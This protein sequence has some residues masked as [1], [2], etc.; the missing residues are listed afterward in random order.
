MRQLN[1]SSVFLSLIDMTST[2]TRLYRIFRPLGILCLLFSLTLSLHAQIGHGAP[3]GVCDGSYAFCSS[4]V[5]SFSAGVNTGNAQAGPDYDCLGTQP[6]PAWFYMQVED[7]GDIEIFMSSSPSYDI[8][9]CMWGPFDHPTE[10]C[11]GQL[12]LDKVVSCSYSGSATETALVEDALSGEFY[13][14]MITNFSNHPCEITFEQTNVGAPGSGTSNCDIVFE[15]SM[16]AL[17]ATTSACS[18]GYYSVTGQASFTNAPPGGVLIIADNSGKQTQINHPFTSPE[19][20]TLNGIV[21]D[22]LTH[23]ITAHFSD[24]TAC[25]MTIEY[26]APSLPCPSG[27]ITGGGSFCDDGSDIIVLINASDGTPPY[28]F[29]YSYNN[30]PQP[31]VMYYSGPF[32]Y[33]ISTRNEGW[34]RLDS[35]WDS[36]CSTGPLDDSVEVELK[37]IPPLNLGGDVTICGNDSIYLDAGAGMA[38]YLWSTGAH[39][40]GIWA[41]NPGVYNVSIEAVNGCTNFDQINLD[42]F[43]VPIIELGNDTAFCSGGSKTLT[44]PAGMKS[45]EWQNGDDTQS[46]VADVTGIYWLEATSFD[47]CSS[48]DSIEISVQPTPTPIITGEDS[49]CMYPGGELYN[50]LSVPDVLYFWQ[51]DNGSF[52]G[53]IDQNEIRVE[54]LTPTTDWLKIR[55]ITSLGCEGEDSLFIRVSP[56]PGPIQIYHDE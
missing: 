46:I 3:N 22:G 25:A 33:V 27:A 8:D 53:P 7:D 56:R 28:N 41:A 43:P 13:I 2:T 36:Q 20:F 1:R 44:G 48:R 4:D 38:S 17:T 40:Q 54:W 30:I 23:Q 50:V 5:I 34:Y 55:E 19:D 26:L 51:I 32:P 31:P 52:L 45:Y 39:T 9:F 15:C 42:I 16:V 35:I 47:N 24:S 14:L 12:T 18:N 21:C 49:V 37:A 6:N 11:D 29:Q 10:P